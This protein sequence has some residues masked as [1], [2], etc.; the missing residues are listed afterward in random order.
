MATWICSEDGTE[1]P[2][3]EKRCLV[4]RH[5]NVPRVVVLQSVATGKEAEF[6]GAVKFGKAVFTHRFADPDAKY[7]ADLQFEIARDD[8]RAGWTVSCATLPR[9]RSG[10]ASPRQADTR[11]LKN[12]ICTDECG[13]NSGCHCSPTANTSLRTNSTAWIMPCSSIATTSTS[14]GTSAIAWW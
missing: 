6:T 10:A 12:A 14:A 8:E 5:P 4:C 11:A 9:Q 7:A 3:T 13:I 2:G 1:N